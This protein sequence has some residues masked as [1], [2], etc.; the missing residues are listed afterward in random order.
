VADGAAL[1]GTSLESRREA[2]YADQ[3]VPLRSEVD[4][5]AQVAPWARPSRVS[6]IGSTGHSERALQIFWKSLALTGLPALI[7]ATVLVPIPVTF[8]RSRND[9][10]LSARANLR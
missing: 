6:A 4:R 10:P 5:L 1:V 8:I 2:R 3:I 9:Q 7:A